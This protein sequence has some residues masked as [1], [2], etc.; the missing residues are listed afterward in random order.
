M[1]TSSIQ[2]RLTA[3]TE[4][5]KQLQQLITHLSRLSSQLDTA[6]ARLEEATLRRELAEEIHQ[7]LEEQEEG[8]ELLRQDAEDY[9]N[10]STWSPSAWTSD[11]VRNG[12][13]FELAARVSK[14]G[15]DQRM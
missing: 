1:N 8:F 4:S 6:D 2:D 9:A 3:L 10:K 5:L 15:E 13:K 11:E 7:S 14:L 12:Q